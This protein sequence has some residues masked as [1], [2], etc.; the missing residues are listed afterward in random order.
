MYK[1]EKEGLEN[2]EQQ[3]LENQ[4]EQ[5]NQGIDMEKLSQPEGFDDDNYSDEDMRIPTAEEV[6]GQSSENI[7]NQEG[8]QD[9]S[10]ELTKLDEMKSTW[11]EMFGDNE[12]PEDAT[13][14]D[15]DEM[16]QFFA[17]EKFKQEKDKYLSDLPEEVLAIIEANRQ[18][19]DINEYMKNMYENGSNISD[20][21]ILFNDLKERYPNASEEQLNNIIGEMP[22]SMKDL[23]LMNAKA[24][25]ESRQKNFIENQKARQAE[26]QRLEQEKMQKQIDA[27]ISENIATFESLDNALGIKLSEADKNNFKANFRE[28]V[29]PNP[30]TGVAPL[31]EKLQSRFSEIA[32]AL[33]MDGDSR[34][35][36][37][38]SQAKEGVKESWMQKLDD[39]PT[40]HRRS[41]TQDN[42]I[43]YDALEAPEGI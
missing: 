20:D 33:M 21:Q 25:H 13:E 26:A 41:G 11:K 38:L 40:E 2:Q 1:E 19:V 35:K 15:Y 8:T 31:M 22:K 29:T 4:E 34:Y 14:E 6:S 39:A 37:S 43:D 17:E 32:F 23:E 28:W 3:G 5:S 30:E 27:D 12:F 36:S 9:S 18:G 24:N 42:Q 10:Q 16:N 7:D